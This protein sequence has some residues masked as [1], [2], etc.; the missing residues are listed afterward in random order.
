M[1]RYWQI[2]DSETVII[3]RNRN[4]YYGQSELEIND[5]TEI[6]KYFDVISLEKVEKIE[7]IENS[8]YIKLFY[9]HYSVTKLYLN[10]E[11][12]KS[13]IVAFIKENL[14]EFKYKKDLPTN[15]DYAKGHYIIII[16]LL[17]FFCC[18]LYFA[19]G[20]SKG[21]NFEL[22][23]MKVGLIHFCL[24]IAKIGILN[25]IIVFTLLLSF[26]IF[27]LQKKLR[28]KGTVETL[29]KKK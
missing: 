10:I 22:R 5:S 8:N 17:F 21:K 4:I 6:P 18:S 29:I 26:V 27:V 25:L 24:Y 15:I 11:S 23:S 9:S 13:E 2:P 20:I 16:L 14:T 28:L 3:I 7:N 1:N 12:I 19:I